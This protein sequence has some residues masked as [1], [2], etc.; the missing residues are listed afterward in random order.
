[1][2]NIVKPLVMPIVRRAT[3]AYVAGE[4]IDAGIDLASRVRD[5]GFSCTLCY[6]NDGTEEPRIVSDEYLKILSRGS[7]EGLDLAL[8]AKL[9][10][11]WERQE[12]VD[13]VVKKAREVGSTVIFDSHDPSKSDDTLACIEQTG[14]QGMGM[15]IPGR[16]HRSLE[17]AERAIEM[18]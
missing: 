4:D 2:R 7:E 11:L 1:M 17:D 10:A 6:W 18:I 14:P 5:A 9:P 16:W 15:A 3:R 8:S 13:R 12:E